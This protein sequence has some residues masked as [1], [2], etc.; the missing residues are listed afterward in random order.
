MLFPASSSFHRVLLLG[1]Q[2]TRAR[3][4]REANVTQQQAQGN[5]VARGGR[6]GHPAQDAGTFGDRPQIRS[7]ARVCPLT[8]LPSGRGQ[9]KHWEG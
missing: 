4:P 2:F 9:R 3:P 8:T 7:P 5:K 1:R 6:A